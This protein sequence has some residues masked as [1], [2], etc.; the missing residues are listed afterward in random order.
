MLRT[1]PE[2]PSRPEETPARADLLKLLDILT[3]FQA[4]DR[5]IY[6]PALGRVEN[7][8]EHSY[9][10][11]MAAWLI[12]DRDNLPLDVDLVIKY[13]LVHDLVEVYAGDTFAFDDEAAKDK[14]AREH[15]ALQKLKENESTA[16]FAGVAEKYEKLEDEESRFVYGLDK[17]MAAFTTLHGRVPIWREHGIPREMFLDRFQVKI[18]K[19]AHLRPYLDK[20]L[21]LLDADPSLLAD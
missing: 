11:A 18:E 1:T 19:S 17:L 16:G 4:V 14:P 13:A 12:A 6:L 2:T 3:D 9:N 7:D 20:L 21:Q 10:L 15:A 5:R 8:T